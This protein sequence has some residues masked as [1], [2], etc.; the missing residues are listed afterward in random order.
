MKRQVC[1]FCVLVAGAALFAASAI[2]QETRERAD[3]VI[4]GGTVVTMDPERRILED[5]AV[6]VR[7]DAILDVGPRAQ[8]EAKYSAATHID[9]TVFFY[10]PGDDRDQHPVPTRR[11]SEAQR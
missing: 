9:A 6:A 5:G 7:G 4:A 8:I 1:C 3:L 11:S 2:E 10:W